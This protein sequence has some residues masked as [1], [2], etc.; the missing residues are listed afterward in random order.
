[1]RLDPLAFADDNGKVGRLVPSQLLLRRG[2][3]QQQRADKKK[4]DDDDDVWRDVVSDATPHLQA[5]MGAAAT[6]LVDQAWQQQDDRADAVSAALVTSLKRQFAVATA[7]DSDI[8]RKTIS[9]TPLSLQ[10][11]DDNNDYKVLEIP[12]VDLVAAF[13]RALRESADSYLQ[14]YARRKNLQVPCVAT[15]TT[16]PRRCTNV[17]L[18]VPAQYSRPQRQLM[19]EAARTAGFSG[20]AS[21]L[22]EST[23]AALA[24]YGLF[25]KG[26]AAAKILIFDMGGGTTDVTIAEY[27]TN[28][29][30][31]FRVLVTE[32]DGRLG[33]NDMDQA[34]LEAVLRKSSLTEEDLSL[35]QRRSLL[36]Q[37]QRAK[38]DLCRNDDT[39]AHVVV[40]ITPNR[41]VELVRND[42]DTAIEPLLQRAETVV[43]TAL[44]QAPADKM[45]E[46]I[47]I[48]GATQTPAVRRMLQALFPRQELCTAVHPM[49]AVAQGAAIQAAILSGHVPLHELESAL[50]MDSS[51]HAIGVLT[52]SQD[53][54]EILPKDSPLPAASFATFQLA[55]LQQPGVAVKA[56]EE[57]RGSDDTFYAPLGEFTFLLHRLTES[58]QKSLGGH[59]SVD[60]GMT[61]QEDG[62]FAVSI[63]DE[64]D[65][66]HV[67]KK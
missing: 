31:R 6:R 14:K 22:T 4:K 24:Y 37:C 52:E 53:F 55:D 46:V 40:T 2:R 65:P 9:V 26:N 34:L 19:V 59:R 32:G 27:D 12:P 44:Q 28:A 15:T 39:S 64:N 33:G 62:A 47:L 30:D 51:P 11:N 1:M 29:Q 13:L 66:E 21:T 58:E 23:A 56:V 3:R 43:K 54:V 10:E 49:S 8:D 36:F 42:L 16:T 57:I 50:M 25:N 17:V 35:H 18:G 5:A 7:P 38:E 60:I 20:H 67:R 41:R 63:F 61:L 48:G 45:D